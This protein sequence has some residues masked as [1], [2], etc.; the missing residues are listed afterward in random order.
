MQTVPTRFVRFLTIL[1]VVICL[2]V[3]FGWR[4]DFTILKSFNA[5]YTT[6]KANTALC[7][8]GTSIALM[9]LSLQSAEAV[10]RRLVLLCLAIPGI[11]SVLTLSEFIFDVSLGVDQF[12]IRDRTPSTAHAP[13]PGRMSQAHRT[14][15]SRIYAGHTWY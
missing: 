4:N 9:L 15:V 8:L 3:L 5:G 1:P 12:F 13:F 10:F 2:L 6:M 7:V 14:F 11:I